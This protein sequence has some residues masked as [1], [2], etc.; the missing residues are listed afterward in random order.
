LEDWLNVL[1]EIDFFRSGRRQFA[2]VHGMA[3]RG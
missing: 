2:D 1:R 3:A